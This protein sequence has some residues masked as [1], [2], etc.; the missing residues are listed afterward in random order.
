MKTFLLCPPPVADEVSGGGMG[1]SW[2]Q[3]NTCYNICIHIYNCQELMKSVG[4]G[5]MAPLLFMMKVMMVWQNSVHDTHKLMNTLIQCHTFFWFCWNL[6]N[7][8]PSKIT[9]LLSFSL[10]DSLKYMLISP[11]KPGNIADHHL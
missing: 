7:S 3:A 11:A 2:Q 8:L 10:H 5:V 9:L 1:D 4:G 6:Q